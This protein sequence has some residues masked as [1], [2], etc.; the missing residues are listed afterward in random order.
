MRD[1]ACVEN[2]GVTGRAQRAA[3]MAHMCLRK[4]IL[5]GSMAE[6]CYLPGREGEAAGAE[7]ENYRALFAVFW[8]R[9]EGHPL[10]DR[11]SP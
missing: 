6:T 11:S 1:L 9:S 4:V 8:V 5:Q 2:F 7:Q 10:G 3:Q